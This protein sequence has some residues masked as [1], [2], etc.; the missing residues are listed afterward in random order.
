MGEHEFLA[1]TWAKIDVTVEKPRLKYSIAV[2]IVAALG[3]L[4]FGYDLGVLASVL[5]MPQFTSTLSLSTI[6]KTNI[7]GLF[8]VGCTIGSLLQGVFSDR[9][10]RKW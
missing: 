2:C 10:G 7:V 1:E 8:L 4:C 9:F 6:D 5:I 3:G